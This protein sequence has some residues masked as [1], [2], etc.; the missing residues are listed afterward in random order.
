MSVLKSHFVVVLVRPEHPAN[1]GLVARNMKNT[2]FAQLRLVGIS[3][4]ADESLKTAVHARE[5]LDSAQIYDRLEEATEDLEVVFAATSKK[6]KN[7]SRFSLEDAIEKM[8]LFPDATKVGL[9]FGNERT[10]LT[11]DELRYSHFRFTIPQ[12]TK[13]PSFN[14]ASAVLITLFRIFTHTPQRSDELASEKPLPQ[15]KQVECIKIILGKLEE[16]GFIHK[17]N[18][19]HM[20]EMLHDLFGRFGMTEG[21]RKLLLAIFSK[22]VNTWKR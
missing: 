5:I 15:K 19:K 7:F 14:L 3:G 16:K 13:Q 17:T 8:A 12:A 18:K 2:G 22:G 10:G 4:I 20:T 1:I 21:D 11:S 6:R 9:L